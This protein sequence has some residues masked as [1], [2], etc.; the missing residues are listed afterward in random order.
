M[1]IGASTL[2][3]DTGKTTYTAQIS[4]NFDH[5][6]TLWFNVSKK[7]HNYVSET[8]DAALLAMILP[9][10][11]YGEDIHVEGA[12]ES[13]FLLSLNGHVQKILT[14]NMPYLHRIR[15]TCQNPYFTRAKPAGV[16][17]GFSCGVDSFATLQQFF[18]AAEKSEE[19][20]LTHLT[21]HNFGS[22]GKLVPNLFEKRFVNAN[23]VAEALKIPLIKVD[24]NINDFYTAE[25]INFLKSHTLRNC[26]VAPLLNKEIGVYLASSAYEYSDLDFKTKGEIAN[27]DPILLPA[28]SSSS[29]SFKSAGA[30]VSRTEKIALMVECTE[31]YKTLDV[32]LIGSEDKNCGKCKK[33]FRTLYTLKLLGKDSF[34]A[35][36][37][38]ITAFEKNVTKQLARCIFSRNKLDADLRRFMKKNGFKFS[39]I[40]YVRAIFHETF[41]KSLF[42]I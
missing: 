41:W 31:S 20:K 13:D 23:R 33:C 18:L 39:L 3:S 38:N 10:M 24:S 7:Y 37:F 19:F 30:E 6:E 27:Y 21:F 2:R 35:S 29:F 32:C 15:V 26:T 1:L 28:L 22:H 25:G 5:P 8:S 36:V 34:Y 42:R 9:A 4:S 17:T 11:F 16:A 14:M 40:S 12:V